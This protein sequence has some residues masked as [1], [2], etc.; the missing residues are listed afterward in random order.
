M[1]EIKFRAKS[2]DGE[3]IYFNLHESHLSDDAEVFYVGSI[4]CEA[5]TEQEFIG[6]KDKNSEEIYE[7]DIIVLPYYKG[8]QTFSVRELSA[9][10]V[11]LEYGKGIRFW[12]DLPHK[13]EMEVVGN[14]YEHPELLTEMESK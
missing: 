11:I 5:G 13:N 8:K 10:G 3:L 9:Y 1:R 2:L 7:G 6:L 4:P 14:L 12:S